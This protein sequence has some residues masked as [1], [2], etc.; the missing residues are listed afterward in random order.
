M[1]HFTREI[2]IRNY[3]GNVTTADPRNVKS[4][5]ALTVKCPSLVQNGVLS[6]PKAG[7]ITFAVPAVPGQYHVMQYSVRLCIYSQSIVYLSCHCRKVFMADST[8][9]RLTNNMTCSD[10]SLDSEI[11]EKL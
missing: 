8:K 4:N 7:N 2:S 11:L 5:V 6:I 9:V 3:M 1:L 10:I